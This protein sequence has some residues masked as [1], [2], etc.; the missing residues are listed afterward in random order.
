MSASSVLEEI[1][2]YGR[3]FAARR[4]I[5]SIDLKLRVLEWWTNHINGTD[6]KAFCGKSE[7]ET[8]ADAAGGEA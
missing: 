4:L 5:L 2:D 8:V 7:E 1:G 3:H 6:Y